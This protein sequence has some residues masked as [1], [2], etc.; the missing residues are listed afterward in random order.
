MREVHAE[1]VAASFPGTFFGAGDLAVPFEHV[2]GAV[3]VFDGLGDEAEGV[4]ASPVLPLLLETV[5][6]Q[7]VYLLFL[8]LLYLLQKPSKP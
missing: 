3:L 7:L 6:H 8:H 1:Y 2:G 4:V 5:Y